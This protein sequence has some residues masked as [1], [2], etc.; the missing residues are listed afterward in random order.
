MAPGYFPFDDQPYRLAMG[1]L[2]LKA[3]DWIEVDDDLADDLREKRRLLAAEHATVFRAVAGSEA[4]Q[5]EVLELLAEFLPRRFPEIYRLDGGRLWIGPLEDASPLTSDDVAPLEL[6]GRLVQ[7]DLCLMEPAG[8]SYDLTAASVCFPTRW[9]LPS[10]IGRPLGPIHAPVPGFAE[11]LA[12]PVDRFFGLIKPDKP[13]WRANWSLIDSPELFQPRGH[14]RTEPDRSITVDTAGA[15]I[16][17]RVERQT[18]RRLPRT[19]GVLFTIRIYNTVLAE[20]AATPA[21]AG[22]MLA[23]V[24]TMPAA[25]QGYKS[26]AVFQPALEQYLERCAAR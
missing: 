3:D 1:L 15:R 5:Q 21:R 19:G 14:F 18:L 26:V 17:L 7:E 2:P 13:V 8:A 4:G 24:R 16:W 10:K 9:D 23:A 12:R 6:A 25:M 22:R 20:A 11:K